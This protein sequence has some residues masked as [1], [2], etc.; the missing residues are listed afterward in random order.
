MNGFDLLKRDKR[1]FISNNLF[2]TPCTLSNGTTTQSDLKCVSNYIGITNTT[3]KSADTNATS[4]INDSA[5]AVLNIDDV[6]I[7]KPETNWTL[8][9][10]PRN[11]EN[12]INFRIDY[13]MEDRTTGI[14]KLSLSVISTMR[15]NNN[16]NLN[17]NTI[18]VRANGGI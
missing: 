13:V 18:Q 11:D 12:I 14:Y 2:S 5:E 10:A 9:F 16:Q 15:Q 3:T 6:K 4:I 7:G 8:S 1:L 17:N